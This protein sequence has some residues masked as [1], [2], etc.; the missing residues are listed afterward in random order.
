MQP[1]GRGEKAWRDRY[2]AARANGPASPQ[3]KPVIVQAGNGAGR[4]S[5]GAGHFGTIARLRFVRYKRA[6]KLIEAMQKAV[7]LLP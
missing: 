4:Q 5:G 6:S 1:H 7:A 3:C 2:Q